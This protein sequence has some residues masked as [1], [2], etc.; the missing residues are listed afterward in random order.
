MD[1]TGSDLPIRELRER[2]TSNRLDNFLS[3]LNLVP[4]HLLML[5]LLGVMVLADWNR[6]RKAGWGHTAALNNRRGCRA[7]L[8]NQ[9]CR[10]A[11]FR[12]H[13]YI[14]LMA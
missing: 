5:V 4:W 3:D 10:K 2:L 8:S 14:R 1:L 11:V 9:D 12:H 7:E 13:R 6:F